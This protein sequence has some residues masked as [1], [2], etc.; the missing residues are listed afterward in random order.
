MSASL[1]KDYK[2]SD[3]LNRWD[4][5]RKIDEDLEFP[6]IDGAEYLLHHI[7]QIGYTTSNGM[8]LSPVSYQE[9][10][11]YSILNGLEFESWEVNCLKDMSVQYCRYVSDKN[12][13]STA[14]YKK[15]D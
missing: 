2:H 3:D 4:I 14:P 6:K 5:Y 10:M 11:A 7:K 9:I 15:V 13:N 8:G 1:D 12:P